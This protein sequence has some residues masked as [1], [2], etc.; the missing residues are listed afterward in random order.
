MQK[1]I[2]LYCN[3]E[4]EEVTDEQIQKYVH[5]F[6][7][8]DEDEFSIFKKQFNPEEFQEMFDGVSNIIDIEEEPEIH[9]QFEI[10]EDERPDVENF[11]NQYPELAQVII[12]DYYY[13]VNIL[14]HDSMQNNFGKNL[15]DYL[16]IVT[17]E[18]PD[19]NFCIEEAT[20]KIEIA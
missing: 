15:I 3:P 2:N 17:H 12:E 8:I 13:D 19:L 1:K 9:D 11:V 7:E 10:I 14:K 16:E 4:S 20:K 5:R 6:R 18:E